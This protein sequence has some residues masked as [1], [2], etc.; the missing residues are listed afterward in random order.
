MNKE[1]YQTLLE[2]RKILLNEAE[3]LAQMGSWK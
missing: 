2:E 1:L 3:S